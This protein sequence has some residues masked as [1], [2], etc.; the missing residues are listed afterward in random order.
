[1]QF[2]RP[3]RRLARGALAILLAAS[4]LPT[5]SG[6]VRAAGPLSAS[7]LHQRLTAEVLG[8]LPYWELT[9]PTVASLNYRRLSTIVFFSVGMDGAGHLVRT[10][11]GYTALMSSRA[12]TVIAAAHTAGVRVTVSFTSFGAAKNAAFFSNAAAQATFVAEAAALVKTR[13][14]DGADLDVELI[15]GTYFD[16][17]AATA[18]ALRA[19][20]RVDNPIAHMTVATNGN[21]SGARMAAK[22]VARGA[23]RAFL[24]GYS[25]RS[26]GSSPGSIDP[27]VRA[28]GGLSLTSSLDL[29]A[30][31]GVPAN[32]ILVGLPFYGRTWQTVDGG[33][34]SAKVTGTSG[35]TT[36]I[37]DIPALSRQG[38]ILAWDVDKVET[39]ARLVRRVN[40]VIYQTYY[41]TPATLVPKLTLALSRRLA[42]AGFWTLGYER[43]VPGYWDAVGQVFG[44]PTVRLVRPAPSPTATP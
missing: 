28:D 40:G 14:L 15:S 20:M 31:Y 29:Y 37:R 1:V 22:A 39:S 19:R 7:Q 24:M 27:L 16:A 8:Y 34:R 12:S 18:G 13:G 21:V 43:G 25:Y 23:D 5:A 30:A 6:S 3:S 44:R 9:D 33:V 10:S 42:G 35:T 4:L 26:S 38:T 2:R 36:L 32:R 41:D 11:A 17:Y